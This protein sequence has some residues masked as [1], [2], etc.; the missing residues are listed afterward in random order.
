MHVDLFSAPPSPVMQITVISNTCILVSWE[1]PFP[2]T[3]DEDVHAAR[4]TA[5]NSGPDPTSGPR[6]RRQRSPGRL[7]RARNSAPDEVSVGFSLQY[8]EIG[9][10]QHVIKLPATENK[11]LIKDLSE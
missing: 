1:L 6:S 7:K 2:L 9:E 8:R 3:E 5:N 11:Y 4:R 10:L